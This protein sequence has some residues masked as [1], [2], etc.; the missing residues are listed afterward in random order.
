MVDI[1]STSQDKFSVFNVSKYIL[2]NKGLTFSLENLEIFAKN[3]NMLRMLLSCLFRPDFNVITD[4]LIWEIQ[5]DRPEFSVLHF[6][7]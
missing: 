4:W 3:N 2:C 1:L 7:T 6:L 5:N